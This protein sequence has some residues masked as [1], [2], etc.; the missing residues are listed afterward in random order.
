MF[1]VIHEIVYTIVH[2]RIR[3]IKDDCAGSEN[4][5]GGSS[6]ELAKETDE[7]LY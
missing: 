2:E 5:G 3:K 1:S 4:T 6:P 7:T